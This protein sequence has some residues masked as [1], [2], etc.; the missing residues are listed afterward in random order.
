VCSFLCIQAC[1]EFTGQS[2]G[3]RREKE[4]KTTTARKG[5]GEEDKEEMKDAT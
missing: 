2:S 4:I 3:T 5:D 1:A